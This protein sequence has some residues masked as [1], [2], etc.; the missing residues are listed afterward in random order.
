MPAMNDVEKDLRY[1][2]RGRRRLKAAVKESGL[3]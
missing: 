2:R 1:M 3:R